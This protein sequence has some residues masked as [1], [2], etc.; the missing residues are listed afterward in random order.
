[1]HSSA[2][3]EVLVN[4]PLELGASIDFLPDGSV[5]VTNCE[6]EILYPSWSFEAQQYRGLMGHLAP[7]TTASHEKVT[8]RILDI[9]TENRVVRFE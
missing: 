1:M 9:D 2:P 8:R 5:L 4:P 6:G 3:W 7:S